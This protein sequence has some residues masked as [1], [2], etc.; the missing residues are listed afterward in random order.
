MLLDFSLV[1]REPDLQVEFF[2]QQWMVKG[3]QKSLVKT[4][5]F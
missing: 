1:E 4:N 3:L 5:S 2:R